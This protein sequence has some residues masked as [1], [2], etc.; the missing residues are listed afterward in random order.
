[1]GLE[2]PKKME[3]NF[4]GEFGWELLKAIPYAYSLYLNKVSIK[5]ISCKDTNCLYYFSENHEE[6]HA[7][8]S[9]MSGHHWSGSAPFDS[10]HRKNPPDKD[11][12][13]P[14]PYKKIFQNKIKSEKPTFI[15]S[16]KYNTEWGGPPINYISKKSLVEMVSI[17]KN[18][19][20]VY[21][22]RST[23]ITS[24]NSKI[25]DLNEKEEVKKAGAVLL[26]E[27]YENHKNITF[28]TFQMMM[29]AECD[30]FISVQGGTS[31]L[32]S[33]FEGTNFILSRKGQELSSGS[34]SWYKILSGCDVSVFKD[35]EEIIKKITN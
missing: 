21:Y 24:D 33:Y 16:N 6:R 35:E 12:W 9:G 11:N 22:N 7:T 19:Y 23:K 32:S 20:K 4:N 18:K 8:R 13:T 30:K 5:T 29:F 3:I 25:L 17:L 28:N 34:Y 15:I 10:I 1:M 2:N 14:P 27:E 26:E 31:I